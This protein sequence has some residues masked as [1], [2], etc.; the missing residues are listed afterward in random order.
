MCCLFGT[1]GPRLAA[2]G[3]DGLKLSSGS[4]HSKAGTGVEGASESR[5]AENKGVLMEVENA[6]PKVGAGSAFG[7]DLNPDGG[8]GAEV[9]LVLRS[10]SL[11]AASS[12][13]LSLCADRS[14]FSAAAVVTATCGV[15]L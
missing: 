7:G 2:G 3:V 13:R 9:A 5:T 15:T 11:R 10:G 6:A 14:A 1:P 12:A 8:G 4:V